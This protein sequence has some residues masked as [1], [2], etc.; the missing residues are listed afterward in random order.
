MMRASLWFSVLVSGAPLGS[1]PRI[2]LKGF[3]MEA[4]KHHVHIT[5]ST[6][7]LDASA[8]LRF[9][10]AVESTKKRYCRACCIGAL[11]LLTTQ[12]S[13]IT[14]LQRSTLTTLSLSLCHTQD[15]MP[16]DCKSGQTGGTL[17]LMKS[18][19]AL[20][21]TQD[22]SPPCHHLSCHRQHLQRSRPH[23]VVPQGRQPRRLLRYQCQLLHHPVLRLQQGKTMHCSN[24]R[25]SQH[26]SQLSH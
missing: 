17:L 12:D 7:S 10:T 6:T 19:T 2:A 14:G 13:D 21:L 11:L 8:S 18:S 4:F 16:E 24:S 20:S 15:C 23:R 1:L 22:R 25:Q 9:L 5:D 26:V 3:G